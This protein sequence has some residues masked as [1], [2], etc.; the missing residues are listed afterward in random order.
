VRFG[1][2]T[3]SPVIDPANFV[4]T[5]DNPYTRSSRGRRSST[6]ARPQRVSNETKETETLDPEAL[7]HK[8]YAAGVGNVLT[9]DLV[10]GE[11]LELIRIAAM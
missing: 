4:A 6:R 9:V 11:R 2:A 8:Y 3:Y 1:P 7:E 5:I 10:T